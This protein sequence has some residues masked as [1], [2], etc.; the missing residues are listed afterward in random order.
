MRIYLFVSFFLMAAHFQFTQAQV[1]RSKKFLVEAN[2][3][4]EIKNENKV[5]EIEKNFSDTVKCDLVLNND[6]SKLLE[7]TTVKQNHDT[8]I[9]EIYNHTITY[10]NHYLTLKIIH[11]KYSVSYTYFSVLDSPPLDRRI[12]NMRSKLILNTNDI[13]KRSEIRGYIEYSGKC[14]KGCTGD[15][16][17]KGNFK[18]KIN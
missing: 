18:F 2:R 1:I 3:H 5:F 10:D 11:Q 16:F 8:I 4:F 15:V 17:L 9:I 7:Y 12:D 14:K 13:A 6:P